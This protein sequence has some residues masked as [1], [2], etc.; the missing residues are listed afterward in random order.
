MN[1]LIFEEENC[2][3]GAG[4]TRKTGGKCTSPLGNTEINISLNTRVY[5]LYLCCYVF[6][7]LYFVFYILYFIFYILYFIFCILYFVSCISYSYF[8]FYRISYILY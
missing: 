5:V 1:T 2:S 3:A 4:V 8:I 7:V 6:Y